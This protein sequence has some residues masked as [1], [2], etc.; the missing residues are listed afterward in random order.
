MAE[1]VLSE[2]TAKDRA[3][4]QVIIHTV[5]DAEG[6][7][8]ETDRRVLRAEELIGSSAECHRD[9]DSSSREKSV[10]ENPPGDSSSNDSPQG[11]LLWVGVHPAE[12]A[13]ASGCPKERQES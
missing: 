6:G 9:G 8:Y 3:R 4:H 12:S 1:S 2:G 10:D 13:P 11:R 7:W 5:E